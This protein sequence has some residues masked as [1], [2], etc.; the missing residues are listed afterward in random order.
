[1]KKVKSR[2]TL[3]KEIKKIALRSDALSEADALQIAQYG[4]RLTPS[5][6]LFVNYYA[7]KAVLEAKEG[8]NWNPS[9]KWKMRDPNGP[10]H[11]MTFRKLTQFNLKR[12]G[13]KISKRFLSAVDTRDFQIILE[14]AEAIRFFKNHIIPNFA[15]PDRADLLWLKRFYSHADKEEDKLTLA[16]SS[17]ISGLE[18]EP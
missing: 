1:M 6:N 17:G 7:Y 3:A 8:D 9:R 4:R 2:N 18:E 12:E 10:K 16:T 14:M 5:E 11:P 15:D 13:E